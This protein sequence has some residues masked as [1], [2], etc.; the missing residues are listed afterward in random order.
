MGRFG[1][2]GQRLKCKF[3]ASPVDSLGLISNIAVLFAVAQGGKVTVRTESSV[4]HS[5]FVA[6]MQAEASVRLELERV[7]E[8]ELWSD[9]RLARLL[10]EKCELGESTRITD[11]TIVRA[12]ERGVLEVLFEALCFRLQLAGEASDANKVKEVARQ[13]DNVRAL[14]PEFDSPSAWYCRAAVNYA[15]EN[16]EGALDCFRR[17][18]KGLRQMEERARARRYETENAIYHSKLEEVVRGWSMVAS[19]KM[20]LGRPLAASRIVRRLLAVVSGK[21][22]L[23]ALEGGLRMIQGQL[24]ERRGDLDRAFEHFGEAH[25]IYLARHHWYY[26]LKAVLGYARIARKRARFSEARWYLELLEDATGGPEFGAMQKD[27]EKE[28][29]SL[30]EGAVDLWVDVERGVVRTRESREVPIGKQFVLLNLLDVLCEAH[31]KGNPTGVTKSEIIQRV[32]R[33]S[34]SANAHDNKLYY[35]INRL[36]RLL[37]PD[38]GKPKYLLNWKEGYRLAPDLNVRWIRTREAKK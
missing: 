9:L 29:R 23:S 2:A 10:A 34:Y 20:Y 28:R 33:E 19:M 11:R 3:M 6:P 25:R 26:H 13:I 18:L 16:V 21:R 17:Y 38:V 4:L 15:M 8:K 31:G 27:I 32:W 37:E 1:S 22:E 12:R 36:R 14:A 35:N 24:A 7:H 30:D 5:E